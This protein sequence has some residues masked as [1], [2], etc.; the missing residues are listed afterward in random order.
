MRTVFYCL[1][2]VF[3]LLGVFWLASTLFSRFALPG[4]TAGL[5]KLVV[6]TG[7]SAGAW[8]LYRAYQIG[9]G[10]ERWAS[11]AAVVLGAVAACQGIPFLAVVFMG[12]MQRGK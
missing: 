5:S 12:V 8:L 10:E 1:F 2:G 7:C 11:A 6:L 4:M 9:E 3:G